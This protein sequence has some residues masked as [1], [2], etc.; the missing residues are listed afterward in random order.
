MISLV[1]RSLSQKSSLTIAYN[2]H[3]CSKSGTVLHSSKRVLGITGLVRITNFAQCTFFCSLP[4]FSYLQQLQR[5]EKMT[6]AMT[7]IFL[8]NDREMWS[9]NTTF[10]DT[11]ISMLLSTSTEADGY[12]FSQV[13]KMTLTI[14]ITIVTLFGLL[15]NIMVILI[16]IFFSDMHTLINFS[17]ANLALTDMTMLLL[18]AVPTAA[19][20]IGWNLSAKFGCAIPIYLQ[21]VSKSHHSLFIT[22]K[23]N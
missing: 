23:L 11:T 16:V 14:V 12:Q 3:T 5:S 13:S 15:G 10:S 7:Q 1:V 21:Y 8:A 9:M 2:F 22:N 19:D 20:T 17:F 4:L 18:D 6:T